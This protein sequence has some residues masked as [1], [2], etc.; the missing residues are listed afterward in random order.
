MTSD[1]EV[2]VSA[3]SLLS[4][5]EQTQVLIDFNSTDS[6]YEKEALLHDVIA[7]VAAEKDEETA[8]VFGDAEM[9]YGDL[10]RL[11]NGVARKLTQDGV[12][13]GDTVGV[14]VDRSPQ[15]IA[16]LL[17]VMRSG[18]AYVPLD[19]DFPQERLEMMLA[20]AAPKTVIQSK[21]SSLK[22]D[23]SILNIA[24][25]EATASS[26]DVAIDSDA[27]A[28]I[29]YTSGSTGTPKGVEISHRAALNFLTSMKETPGF[30]SEDRLLAV[31]TLSFDISLL[32]MFL[33]LMAGGTVVVAGS[34]DVKDGRRLANLLE[35]EDISVM[36]A[37]P[38][39]WQ[40]LLDSGWEGRK[41]LRVFCGGEALT[42]S[43]ANV[44]VNSADELWNLYGPTETTVW[45]TVEQITEGE[46]SI[47]VGKPIANT[48]IYI[49]DDN[50]EPV[51]R[52]FTGELW[53]G[54]DGLARGYRNQPELTAAAF[55][56]VELPTGKTERLYRTGDLARWNRD[57]KLECLGRVDFQVKVRGVRMELGDIE[58]QLATFAGIKQSV[59]VKREDLP[60]AKGLFA[61]YI[62]DGEIDH[63]EL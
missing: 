49:L 30:T 23:W 8:V 47:N 2:K 28:Y 31:T 17:G 3:L 55:V 36:Q 42:R 15:M 41:G 32:E 50:K 26:P 60:S 44:L 18:A 14:L 16:A 51:P 29:I 63:S 39:T 22:G 24:D 6:A 34:E 11:A 21:D 46:E 5:K 7:K 57:E 62:A 56:E 43:L 19:P 20:D 9:T 27:L 33:P 10:N 13:L 52:G 25:V 37:T 40:L 4:E 45:S 35:Q 53:I 48:Q 58:T 38:A 54:G 59:V 61:Y 1:P 12:G